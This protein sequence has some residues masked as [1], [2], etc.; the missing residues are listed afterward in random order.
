MEERNGEKKIISFYAKKARGL[1]ARYII[2][3]R[4]NKIDDLKE[5]NLDNYIYKKELSTEKNLIFL[6]K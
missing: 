4:A 6:R 2:Q 3:K 1:M 5:F